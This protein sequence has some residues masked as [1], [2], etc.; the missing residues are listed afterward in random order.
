MTHGGDWASLDVQTRSQQDLL[1]LSSSISP[2]GPGP[3]ARALWPSLVDRLHRY[4]DWRKEQLTGALANHLGI[5]QDS[6]LVTAGAMEAID[7]VI[8]AFLP[9]DVWVEVP[10]FSEYEARASVYGIGVKTW[11]HPNGPGREPG[12]W[13]LANPAN[14][15]G[16]ML[17]HEECRQYVRGPTDFQ[18][19]TVIDEAFIEFVQSW[20]ERSFAQEAAHS[21]YLVVMGSLTKYYGLAGLRIGFLVAHPRIIRKISRHTTPWHVSLVAQEMALASLA[22]QDYFDGARIRLEK[23]RA[24]LITMLEPF[25]KIDETSETNYLLFYPS[26]SVDDLIRGLKKQGILIRDARNFKGLTSEAVRI[27]V[28]KPKDTTRLM[29]ALEEIYST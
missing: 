28:K 21:D 25:G 22:D 27:A 5:E 20:H 19:I 9:Q 12:L 26:I 4:P 15:T 1:D 23:E 24:R 11:Q 29:H 14:P 10:A 3:K 8:R 2:Y 16:R 17:T 6:V 13:F 18:K 7:L